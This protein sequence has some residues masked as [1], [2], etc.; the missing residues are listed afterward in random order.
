MTVLE[1]RTLLAQYPDTMP[2]LIEYDDFTRRVTGA[3][4]HGPGLVLFFGHREGRQDLE[5]Q[6]LYELWTEERV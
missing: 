1:L 6:V 4:K 5:S 2:V 3:D